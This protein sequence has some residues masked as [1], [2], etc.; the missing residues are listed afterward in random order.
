M[1]QVIDYF[2]VPHSPWT[3][4]GHRRLAAIASRHGA[5][6]RL[7]PCDFGRV[8]EA[9]GGVPLHKR[10]PARQ[11]YRLEELARWRDVLGI[12]LNL[13]PAFFPIDPR[14]ASLA[15]LSAIALAGDG[16]AHGFAERLMRAVW[17]QER[18][19]SDDPTIAAIADEAGLD[20]DEV[21]GGRAAAEPAYTAH[22]D[23]AIAAGVFG[24]PWYRLRGQNFWGQD[25]LDL[26]DRAL[27]R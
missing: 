2:F 5:R 16:A 18:D 14:P 19:I 6:I 1:D 22:T 24:A 20:A 17:V 15:I 10:P 21:L 11:A 23:E 3:Y 12:E 26:L 4:L 9:T 8:F 13:E 27:G 7:K 25:R